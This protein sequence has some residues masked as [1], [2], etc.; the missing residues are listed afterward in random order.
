MCVNKEEII[1]PNNGINDAYNFRSHKNI[2]NNFIYININ[3][4]VSCPTD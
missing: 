2:I 3:R 4:F 1:I